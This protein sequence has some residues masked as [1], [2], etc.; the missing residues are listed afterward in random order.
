[1]T[2]VKLAFLNFL[3]TVLSIPVHAGTVTEYISLKVGESR[4][5]RAPSS[6]NSVKY[7]ELHSS[8][9]WDP[10]TGPIEV[11]GGLT[12]GSLASAITIRATGTGAAKVTCHAVYW[13]SNGTT[14][15][16]KDYQTK[17]W[18][19]ECYDD[20]PGGGG[21]NGGNG[22]YDPDPDYLAINSTNF[23]D[24]NFRNYIQSRFNG[25]S[26]L[27]SVQLKMLTD[28][29][30]NNKGVKSLQGVEYFTEVLEILCDNNN[31]TSLD[32]S[33]NTKLSRLSCKNN[34]ITSLNL[35]SN[36]SLVFLDCS[37]NKIT[38]FYLPNTIV[39]LGCSNNKLAVLNVSSLS[40][41]NELYCDNNNMTTL[42]VNGNSSVGLIH[43]YK[44]KL[45]TINL[46]GCT[47]LTWLAC[48]CNQINEQGAGNLVSSLPSMAFGSIDFFHT[49]DN[50]EGN[51]M[52]SEQI[53]VA[54]NK[55]WT[56][57]QSSTSFA[58]GARE[59]YTGVN[60]S[61][62]D[63][64]NDSQVNGTDLVALTN[65]IIGKKSKTDSADVNKDG[66]VNGTDYV[67]LVNIILGKK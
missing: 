48:S 53:A 21:G 56:I 51:S 54:K 8:T 58:G 44:N 67:A 11:T 1:M 6:S 14:L 20:N 7:P 57:F 40:D 66:Q 47:N 26:S 50:S 33:K 42:N 29:N 18:Y 43:C 3:L 61:T 13:N 12:S 23:P 24:D 55:G 10:Y 32:L 35:T 19:I 65:I 39:Y 27:S 4:T 60:S 62:G 31:I 5:L 46:S 17:I 52:T 15:S 28:I 22:G 38:S 9:Y 59:E 25:Y 64:N 36:T 16:G 34:S 37:N 45:T 2:K 63:I 30:V 49:S 41:L